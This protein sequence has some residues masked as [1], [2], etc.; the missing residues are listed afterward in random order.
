MPR[1]LAPITVGQETVTGTETINGNQI[2]L[3]GT[4]G[5]DSYWTSV[6]ASGGLSANHGSFVNNV[7]ANAF[8]G[9]GSKLTGITIGNYLSSTG[10]T[11]TGGLTGTTG[12]FTTSLSAPALSGIH[13]GDGSKLTGIVTSIG[14]FLPLSG[15]ALSGIVTSTSA[16]SSANTITANNIATQNQVQYLSAGAVKVY[17]FY[18]T[19]TNTLDTVFN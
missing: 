5:K 16:I 13:Y 11:L 9:D 1:F 19:S 2:I 15:G 18:N 3:S 12:V 4:Y 10:G 17:Q 8:Y 6:S 14:N 7:S